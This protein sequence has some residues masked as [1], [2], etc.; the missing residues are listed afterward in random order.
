MGELITEEGAESGSSKVPVH[1][2]D[3]LIVHWLRF[4]RTGLDRSGSA[5][6]Q[7]VPHELAANTSQRFLHGRNLGQD[8]GAVTVLVDHLLQPAHLAL[9]ATEAFQ[10]AVPYAG[11]DRNGLAA[12]G[13]MHRAPA[14]V[15]VVLDLFGGLYHVISPSSDL[16]LSRDAS[17]W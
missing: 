7:V 12:A 8:V 13:V 15:N 11:I 3:Q 14:G 9:Y 10:V 4:I 6:F 16:T 2:V 1:E 5:M 17:C